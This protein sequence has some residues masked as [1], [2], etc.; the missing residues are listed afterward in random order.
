MVFAFGTFEIGMAW[1][2]RQ[3]VTQ[4]ARSGARAA[5][6]LGTNNQADSFAVRAIEGALDHLGD[7]VTRIV[8]FKADATDGEIP[9][10]CET[11]ARPGVTGQCSVYDQRDFGTYTAW[12]QGQWSPA[13]RA[14]GF[15]DADFVGVRVEVSRPLRTRFLG[16]TGVDIA[17]TVVMLIEPD[18]GN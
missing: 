1:S 17:D 7:D 4:S 18:A 12:S 3:V 15:R 8:V 6:Q 2:D 9:A 16:N 5:S 10:A 11:A 14:N 13:S